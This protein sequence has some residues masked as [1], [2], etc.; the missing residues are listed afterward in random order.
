MTQHRNFLRRLQLTI[1]AKIDWKKGDRV[2]VEPSKGEYWVATVTK[3]QRDGKKIYIRYDDG[4]KDDFNPKSKKVLGRAALK[5]KSKKP[6]GKRELKQW[7]APDETTTTVKRQ[8][9]SRSPNKPVEP[10][11]PKKDTTV[12]KPA[13]NKPAKP[14]T[15]GFSKTAPYIV[16]IFKA[17][18]GGSMSA[19][20]HEVERGA[21]W[22]HTR[23]DSQYYTINDKWKVFT[24]PKPRSRFRPTPIDMGTYF[25]LAEDKGTLYHRKGHSSEYWIGKDGPVTIAPNGKVSKADFSKPRGAEN[26]D[27]LKESKGK[28]SGETYVVLMFP[29]TKRGG[30]RYAWADAKFG[31]RFQNRKGLRKFWIK[32]QR[33]KDLMPPADPYGRFKIKAIPGLTEELFKIASDVAVNMGEKTP[34]TSM[35][36]YMFMSG[37]GSGGPRRLRTSRRDEIEDIL[38][39]W[40]NL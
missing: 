36:Y 20:W 31:E 26:L 3:V 29:T 37:K 22:A 11:R 38:Q 8:R 12:K 33:Y 5:R 7:L 32:D 13:E 10:K 16:T 40:R 18:R 17:R 28:K 19:F 27:A 35:D 2:I 39:S 1:T 6:L 9:V 14:A 30:E 21:D 25:E 24:H 4:D 15:K 34:K 23:T